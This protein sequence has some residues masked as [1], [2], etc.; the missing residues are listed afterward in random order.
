MTKGKIRVFVSSTIRDLSDVRS[1]LRYWLEEL[2]FEVLLT[3]LNDFDREPTGSTFDACLDAIGTCDYYILLVGSR[4]GGEFEPGVSITNQEFRVARGLEAEGRLAII[5]FIRSDVHASLPLSDDEAAKSLNRDTHAVNPEKARVNIADI[6]RF[7]DEVSKAPVPS[8]PPRPSGTRFYNKFSTFKE[9]ADA[10]KIQLR[11][12]HTV[13]RRALLAQLLGEIRGNLQVSNESYKG[14]PSPIHRRFSSV[15]KDPALALDGAGHAY[16]THEQAYRIFDFRFGS[17][18]AATNLSSSALLEALQSGEF[19]VFDQERHQLVDDT[20]RVGMNAL[21]LEITRSRDMVAAFSQSPFAEEFAGIIGSL[22]GHEPRT[23]VSVLFLTFLFAL[24]DRL[25]NVLRLS[26]ALARW[27]ETNDGT[28]FLLPPLHPSAPDPHVAEEIER[29]RPTD[30]NVESWIS[31]PYFCDVMT[32]LST[33]SASDWFAAIK[34][35]PELAARFEHEL[36]ATFGRSVAEL[37][38]EMS[39]RIERD[40]VEAVLAWLTSASETTSHQADAEQGT[41]PGRT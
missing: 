11:A 30:A 6:R 31:N 7:W 4:S 1:A 18:G 10:L 22:Q 40:G 35:F 41:N 36:E 26:V 19:V 13:R 14:L 9:L 38:K 20:V 28:P 24:H 12:V 27:I 8:T 37:G 25:E 17:S 5:P 33:A 3:E 2:G 23:S 16:V 21:L 29:E 32:G 15:R 39:N 34:A